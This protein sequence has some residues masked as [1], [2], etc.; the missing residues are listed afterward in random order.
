MFLRTSSLKRLNSFR[1]AENIPCRVQKNTSPKFLF[2]AC[3]W[4][5]CHSIGKQYGGLSSLWAIRLYSLHVCLPYSRPVCDKYRIAVS[6]RY[7][8]EMLHSLW[9]IK[10]SFVYLA[11]L[12][13][14]CVTAKKCCTRCEISKQALYISLVCCFF[15][16]GILSSKKETDS[17]VI[18]ALLSVWIFCFPS[19]GHL[20][21][22][23]FTCATLKYA[24]FFGSILSKHERKI[25]QKTGR[26]VT[27]RCWWLYI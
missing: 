4:R 12:L 20:L 26:V 10:A 19:V 5:D 24:S 1:V 6:L 7:R 27:K 25:V 8:E 14:L 21:Y 13:F 22:G 18:N 17:K 15:E 2:V 11:R 3:K 23:Y 9:N 16:G